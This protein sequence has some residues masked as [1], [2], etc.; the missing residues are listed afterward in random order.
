[1]RVIKPTGGGKEAGGR[2]DVPK[3]A[4]HEGGA[5]RKGALCHGQEHAE[6]WKLHH[7][8]RFLPD[9]NTGVFYEAYPER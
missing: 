6:S 1:M 8:Q 5:G 9:L 3:P 2:R 4:L 7:Q